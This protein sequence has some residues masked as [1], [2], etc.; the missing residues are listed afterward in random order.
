MRQRFDIELDHMTSSVP[1]TGRIVILEWKSVDDPL[2]KIYNTRFEI[3][4]GV[5]SFSADKEKGTD[6][7]PMIS[8]SFCQHLRDVLRAIY[9]TINFK[10]DH[11]V[12]NLE[13]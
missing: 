12:W 10:S 7:I 1:L 2:P 13:E 8:E 11:C 9:D 3:K 4:E 5:Y 6:S